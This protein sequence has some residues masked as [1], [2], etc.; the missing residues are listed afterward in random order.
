MSDYLSYHG[1]AQR[2]FLDEVHR[3]G[4]LGSSH[5]LEQLAAQA[6][7]AAELFEGMYRRWDLGHRGVKPLPEPTTVPPAGSGTVQRPR[8]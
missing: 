3:V 7:E 8:P 4:A 2:L 1:L 5:L 6:L